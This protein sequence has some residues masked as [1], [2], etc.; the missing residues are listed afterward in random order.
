MKITTAD[1]SDIV[2]TLRT[3]IDDEKK[4]GNT[5]RNS[6]G[7]TMRLP[8]SQW[9][10]RSMAT[11]F[12]AGMVTVVPTGGSLAQTPPITSSGLNT[13]VSAPIDQ[14]GGVTQYDITGG[15]RP[16]NG[17]NLFHSFGTFDVPANNIANFLN[18]SGLD[19]SNILARVTG[20][21]V[22]DIFG[23]IQTTDF[24]NANLFLMNP[25][26]IVFGPSAVLNVGGDAYF[27][28][29]NYIRL[30]DN[31]QFTALPS[32]QDAVLS[33]AD[34][35][36]F[37]FL[38]AN[39]ASITVDGSDLSVALGK[40]LALIGGDITVGSSLIAP[41]GK[42]VL[43]ST[44]S[45]GEFLNPS[46]EDAANINGIS[47]TEK[48]MIKLNP[49]TT[50]DVSDPNF[51]ADGRGG[52]V[53]IRGGEFVMDSAVI[54]GDTLGAVDGAETTVDVKVTGNIL[55]D[56]ESFIGS[57]AQ[58]EGRSGKIE[59]TGQNM[60][61]DRGSNIISDNFSSGEGAAIGISLTDS[62]FVGGIS[63]GG[64]NSSIQ[65]FGE[66]SGVGGSITITAES[67]TIDNLATIKTSGFGTGDPGQVNLNL[68]G[69]LNVLNGGSVRSFG[70]GG[71]TGNTTIMADRIFVS[72]QFD[73]FNRS[74]IENL[75]DG[76]GGTGEISLS[77][78]EIIFT[79]G[80]RLN[81]EATNVL[82]AV[83]LSATESITISNHAKIRLSHDTGPGGT[84]NMNAPSIMM[85][86]GVLQ[87]RTGGT[88]DASHVILEGHNVT[89][90]GSQINS[91][92]EEITGRG[93]NVTIAAT[94]TVTITGQLIDEDTG[95]PKPAGIFTTTEKQGGDSGN[96]SVTGQTVNLAAGGQFNSS[97]SG[98]GN[99]GTTTVSTTGNTLTISGPG[100][101]I[102][103]TASGTGAGGN[104][105]VQSTEVQLSNGAAL[106]ASSTGTGNSGNISITASGN[107]QSDSSTVSTSAQQAQGGDIAITAGTDI[108]LRNN[109]TVSAKSFGAGDA[110][111]ITLTGN[112]ATLTASTLTSS[113]S[114]AGNAG[115]LTLNVGSLTGSGATLKS[116]STATGDA[117]QI[118]VQGT[119]GNGAL[120]TEVTLT[121]STVSTA[122]E[123]TGAGGSIT[124]GASGAATLSLA[125]TTITAS[126]RDV[127]AG[128]NANEGLANILLTSPTIAITG[129][130]IT[131]ES[132]GTRQG[133]NI[134]LTGAQAV[135]LTAG[136]A[137][138][139]SSTGAGNSGNVTIS[140][141]TGSVQ[142]NN[143]TVSTSAQQ[144]VGGNITI[145]A[146][147]D[148]ELRNNTTVSAES[149][150]P[151]NAGDITIGGA[152]T[153]TILVENSTI[154]TN[155]ANA[156]GGNIKLDSNFMIQVVNSTISS[157]VGGGAGTGGNINF[158]PQWILIQNSQILAN[159]FEGSGGNI[160]FTADVGIFIDQ[161]S[162]IDASSQFGT[163]GSV[164]ISAPIQNLNGVI[165]QLPEDALRVA[166]LYAERCAAQKGGQFSSFAQG[167]P[168]GLP[169]APGGFLQSPLSLQSLTAPFPAQGFSPTTNALAFRLGFDRVARLADLGP[170]GTWRLGSGPD[171]CA[172]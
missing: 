116:S 149:F 25:A 86:Q 7:E 69:A 96:I 51:D 82:G 111:D 1:N 92:T 58:G 165:S 138:S 90:N 5:V 26:G 121:N 50:L 22:S 142:T 65:T 105:N 155:A 73:N 97:S 6:L 72:G 171:G 36:A 27:T 168:E 78:R 52:T 167:G 28:T 2:S 170:S 99:G 4:R 156:D 123:G 141:T 133:G 43:A 161:F 137:I 49:G 61:V 30:T 106:S 166:T 77:G 117:G 85:D 31:V 41:G 9:V 14:G 159:A 38:D 62:L 34:V 164:N 157:S 48:G 89:L 129:G 11:L 71:R 104:I 108:E 91:S 144:G 93:G 169:P 113:T 39:P 33:T 37:G 115:T 109:T 150:G 110:G 146:G 102:F 120:P 40:T 84:L 124:L 45:A 3:Q 23:T 87:T 55:L 139:A 57:S 47:F 64:N 130:A 163:S 88:G 160:T 143:A 112:T 35:G 60:R 80:A 100:S 29:A 83:T 10:A 19:T 94:G 13:Q 135:S 172:A 98:S 158:D 131:A 136:A 128:A 134:T 32:A 42:V 75:N 114:A 127:P 53:Y 68:T 132:S 24:G 152:N 126:V 76:G 63:D 74:K 118:I 101:G 67:A 18:D 153:E 17:G 15:T 56:N 147:Q 119:G 20:N 154:R 162:T 12:L 95:N 145:T 54:I 59:F 148:V 79:D 125:N 21:N 140:S 81:N 46:F 66:A 70:V 122:A 151:N 44:A 16:G 8:C 103:S 107:V